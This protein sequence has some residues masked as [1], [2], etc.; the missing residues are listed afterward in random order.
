MRDAGGQGRETGRNW[1]R[2]GGYP[3]PGEKR[4]R[5]Q[6]PSSDWRCQICIGVRSRGGDV[7]SEVA[8]HVAL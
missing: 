3:P 4:R 6:R 8:A 1:G 5:L 7:V 2:G